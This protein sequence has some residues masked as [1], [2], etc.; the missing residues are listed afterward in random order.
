MK[1]DN[2]YSYSIELNNHEILPLSTMEGK[3]I[4]IVN[5]ALHSPFTDFYPFLESL[6]RRYSSEGFTIIDVPSNQFQNQTPESDEEIDTYC[7][8]EFKTTFLR[9]VKQDVS[10]KNKSE[11]FSYLIRKK[12]FKGFDPNHVLTPV[13]NCREIKKGP[14]WMTSPEIRENFTFFFIDRK[15]KVSKRLEATTDKGKLESSLVQ[16]LNKVD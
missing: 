9:A 3:V 13:L 11:F 7:R 6:Y 8:K 15:G 14:D 10:G 5:T 1:T 16:L 12:K 4:L 2:V